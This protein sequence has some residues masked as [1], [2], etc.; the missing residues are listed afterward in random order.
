MRSGWNWRSWLA[1]FKPQKCL[2]ILVTSPEI[3][4][5]VLEVHLSGSLKYTCILEIVCMDFF[6]LKEG[7]KRNTSTLRRS[8][9]TISH[10]L[11]ISLSTSRPV[12][13]PPKMIKLLFR[14]TFWGGN[15]NIFYV[16]KPNGCTQKFF[17]RS[18]WPGMEMEDN[19]VKNVYL[20]ECSLVKIFQHI[21][22]GG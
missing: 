16:W 9:E 17:T 3:G 18:V 7:K 22:E 5:L 1:I 8:Y 14:L 13:L 21:C 20:S 10:L 4:N 2:N 11:S 19:D 6:F 15:L 12:S